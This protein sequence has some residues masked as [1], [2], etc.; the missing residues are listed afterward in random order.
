MKIIELFHQ[1]NLEKETIDLISS[2]IDDF[3]SKQ[4]GKRIAKLSAD[5]SIDTINMRQMPFIGRAIGN[6]NG[7]DYLD[8]SN[9]FPLSIDV[10]AAR[11]A[12][13]KLDKFFIRKR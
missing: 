6:A 11:Y 13:E 4:I 1:I 9:F 5:A 8:E 12:M 2:E 3:N 10:N 7:K